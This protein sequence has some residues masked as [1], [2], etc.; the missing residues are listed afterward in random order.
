[1]PARK[2]DIVFCL[3]TSDSMKP[4][5][6]AVRDNIGRLVDQLRQ[7]NY[8]WRL[9]FVAHHVSGINDSGGTVNHHD[10][11]FGSTF[12]MLY[13]NSNSRFFTDDVDFF[14]RR[15]DNLEIE[16]D[17]DMLMA[18]DFALD[19]PFGPANETQR[20]VV[21]ISDEPFE[22]NEPSAFSFSKTKVDD[23][24][25]KIQDRHVTLLAIMPIRQGGVAESL[26]EVDR[27]D[28]TPVDE[29]DLG[30]T[31]VDMLSLFR[32]LGKTIS[33]L[34]AQSN[35]EESYQRGLFNQMNWGDG[36]KDFKHISDTK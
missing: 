20:V 13:R 21:L 8:E 22:S 36:S 18:L 7:A 6:D 27:A 17:E 11:L 12:W 25:K 5:I 24:K 10:S 28:F 1:M 23:I 31:K 33:T 4:C 32:Q 35:G 29:G 30:L 2:V 19:M 34:T 14:K 26:A 16:G 15:L 9:D 3:D